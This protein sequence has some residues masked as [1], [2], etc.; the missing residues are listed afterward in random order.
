MAFSEAGA[1]AVYCVDLPEEPEDDWKKVHEYL[2]KI[3]GK[4]RFEYIRGDVRSQVKYWSV[5]AHV[6][7]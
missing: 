7:V 5:W 6:D 1:R 2:G 3:G 4:G